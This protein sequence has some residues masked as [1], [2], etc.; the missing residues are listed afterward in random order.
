MS[1][2]RTKQVQKMKASIA[3]EHELTE[4]YAAWVQEVK[5]MP[6]S[7]ERDLSLRAGSR[8][9]RE[10]GRLQKEVDRQGKTENIA[11]RFAEAV[12]MAKASV[13]PKKRVTYL[14]TI[15]ALRELS[16][17]NTAWYKAEIRSKEEQAWMLRQTRRLALE[18]VAGHIDALAERFQQSTHLAEEQHHQEEEQ[19][20]KDGTNSDD[21]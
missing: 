5:A 1:Q 21:I 2:R 16:D 20:G 14:N 15:V 12:E 4:L 17:L 6:P 7:S 3:A 19:N 8:V 10:V 11:A 13:L 9:Y 18:I